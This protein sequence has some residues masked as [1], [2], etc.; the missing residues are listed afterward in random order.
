MAGIG[1]KHI[2]LEARVTID[3][4][5]LEQAARRVS[6]RMRS[7]VTIDG[8]QIEG[9]SRPLG[10]I[11]GQAD[12][13]TKSLAA[14]NARVIAFG[15]SVA[16]I[17]GVS[18][19]FKSLLVTTAKVEKTFADINIVLN[20]SQK[21][22]KRFGDGIFDVARNTAQS[23]DT[24]AQGALEFARQG[25]SMEESLKRINDA[26]ILT[27]LTG[28]DVTE[29]VEGLTA[30][31]NTFKKE[32]I[33]TGEVINKLAE[34]DIAFAVSSEDLIKGLERAGG[35]AGQARVSFEELASMIAVVQER[36]ARGGSVIGNALRTIFAR[37]QGSEA[38]NA[39]EAIGVAVRD[40]E[41][42]FRSTTAVLEDLSR[43]FKNL[44]DVTQADI[45]Q[46]V[47]GKRQRETLIALFGEMEGGTGRWAKALQTVGS[48]AETAYKKNEQLNDT[49]DAMVKQTGVSIQQLA[50]RIGEIG[51]QDNLK[52]LLEGFNW[53]IDKVNALFSPEEGSSL[54]KGFV[55][56]LGSAITSSP[57]VGLLL[58]IFAK[59]S[60]DVAKFGIQGLKSLLGINRA[61]QQQANLQE[62]ILHTLMREPALLEELN[63]KGMTRVHQE[64]LL[65]KVLKDQ[66][67]EYAKLAMIAKS[68]SPAVYRA[69]ARST[70]GGISLPTSAGGFIPNAVQ[71][72]R[73]NI[74]RGVGGARGGDKP[75]LMS[76]FNFGG[77]RRGPMVAHTGEYIVD[78]YRG[79]GGSAIFNRDMVGSM[80]M[81]RGARPIAAGGYIP[82]FAP[83]TFKQLLDKAKAKRVGARINAAYSAVSSPAEAE[84]FKSAFGVADYN[85]RARASS[86]GETFTS[87]EKK[88]KRLR[89]E[90]A[91]QKKRIY[92]PNIAMIVPQVLGLRRHVTGSKKAKDGKTY[93]VAFDKVGFDPNVDA[94]VRNDKEIDA[95]T[96]KFALN[97]ANLEAAKMSKGGQPQ[98]QKLDK[99]ANT[100][101]ISSLSG[102]IFETAVSSLVKATKE[103]AK[104]PETA[105]WDFFGAQANAN[106]KALFP[107]LGN[108]Q[109]IE[110][111][112]RES[113]DTKSSMFSKVLRDKGIA[114]A[115]KGYIPNF[116]GGPLEE[117]IGREKAAGLPINQIRINQDSR[118]RKASNP[119]GLAVTNT[120]DEPTG[121]IPNFAKKFKDMTDDELSAIF[122]TRGG[123][124]KQGAQKHLE[125]RGID[126][127]ELTKTSK[128][129]GDL[130]TKLFGASFALSILEGSTQEASGVFGDI[131]S[132]GS[133]FVSSLVNAALLIDLVKTPL[134]KLSK[135]EVPAG[136]F[137][138]GGL[139]GLGKGVGGLGKVAGKVLA[140]A[141]LGPPGIALAIGSALIAATSGAL[142]TYNK[143][144]QEQI[145]DVGRKTAE[146]RSKISEEINKLISDNPDVLK[147]Q[148]KDIKDPS[149]LTGSKLREIAKKTGLNLSSDADEANAQL[150]ELKNN[151]MGI[152]QE[153]ESVAEAFTK[154]TTKKLLDSQ[155]TAQRELNKLIQ[156]RIS[157]REFLL[158]LQAK[159]LNSDNLEKK[160]AETQLKLIDL[161][162]K[163]V[164][165]VSGGIISALDTGEI[166]QTD[167][168]SADKAKEYKDVIS[169]IIGDVKNL[170]ITE[171][172]LK[173]TLNEQLKSLIKNDTARESLIDLAVQELTNAKA[174][175]KEQELQLTVSE[176]RELVA[177]AIAKKEEI[178]LERLKAQFSLTKAIQDSQRELEKFRNIEQKELEIKVKQ[179]QLD[180]VNLTEKDKRRIEEEISNLELQ[181]N[182]FS[183]GE[184]L[185]D[186]LRGVFEGVFDQ[187]VA[188]ELLR[189]EDER[190]ANTII[191]AFANGSTTM[192]K[193]LREGLLDSSEKAGYKFVDVLKNNLPPSLFTDSGE[194]ASGERPL[195]GKP[196]LSLQN[197]TPFTP[198]V[199]Q[200]SSVAA[201]PDRDRLEELRNEIGN[202]K[203]KISELKEQLRRLPDEQRYG[204]I[205]TGRRKKAGDTALSKSELINQEI[206]AHKQKLKELDAEWERMWDAAKSQARNPITDTTANSLFNFDPSQERANALAFN[207]FTI[208]SL[209][210]GQNATAN[211]TANTATP[212]GALTQAEAIL[213]VEEKRLKI[214][215]MLSGEQALQG[216]TAEQ[217]ANQF[218]EVYGI[219]GDAAKALRPILEN[220]LSRELERA[221]AA[222]GV[223]AQLEKQNAELIRRNGL[224]PVQRGFE[225]AK[226][227]LLQETDE[228]FYERIA[229]DT[230][231]DFANNMATALS[232]AA[233]GAKSLKDAL[234]DAAQ[235]F[236]SALQQAFMQR[237]VNTL[238]GMVIP[239]KAEGGLVTGGSGVR[240]DVPHMLMGG[241]YVIKK[242][243]VKKYGVGYLE[244]L[245]NQ[246]TPRMAGGGEFMPIGHYGQGAITGIED[247]ER[248]AN[249]RITSGARDEM[250][251]GESS[252]RIGLEPQ[253]SRLTAFGMRRGSPLQEQLWEQQQQAR[254]LIDQKKEYDRQ[255]EEQ[256]KQALKQL[257]VGTLLS[258]GLAYG[259]GKLSNYVQTGKVAD[260]LNMSRSQFKNSFSSSEA[261]TNFMNKLGTLTPN[262]REFFFENYGG[263]NFTPRNWGY[264]KGGMT[265][266][267]PTAM[268]MGGEYVIGKQAVSQYGRNFFESINNMSA[269][270]PRYAV[271]GSTAPPAG[272]S[273]SKE[274]DTNIS[275][276]VNSDGSSQTQAG[277]DNSQ[278]DMKM[279]E[280]IRKEVVKI[281]EEE[282]RVSG[283]F[284]SRRRGM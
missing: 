120:R 252:A 254:D 26:L 142:V 126:V 35:S 242:D 82:N 4:R 88:A 225:D 129:L 210:G 221:E 209:F 76:N 253:S 230:P 186:G 224:T 52:D 33:T 206:E 237:A 248:F 155:V 34:L 141:A 229:R 185:K 208:D 147:E 114:V 135:I 150:I 45:I 267:S 180:D 50:S 134:T 280:R 223:T 274:G 233:T 277:T 83:Q 48:E 25:L 283:A 91:L 200:A 8:R 111:K 257:I 204:S 112:I 171:E 103:Q 247:L 127:N 96:K 77:G 6:N 234:M 90:R 192:E 240:D 236:L 188:P 193:I 75:V 97:L 205:R 207:P 222:K 243:A 190:R 245:N 28:L 102:A 137:K 220:L 133:N 218:L 271:G 51:L 177:E 109:K 161:R 235:S 148:L 5:S 37:L 71:E 284:S 2:G 168:V 44:D 174:L 81:P 173:E 166:F 60:Y 61:A 42:N 89:E 213:T 64:Q 23:F 231:I 197:F 153:A 239:G 196:E 15:A 70:K 270:A 7:S 273:S 232:Q 219:Q 19:A 278:G 93:Q 80:G 59:L 138:A 86:L 16:I 157:E 108:S 132:T 250:M 199:N 47:A 3:N 68:I 92:D 268:L 251:F 101:A 105:R 12:E 182:K 262:D 246:V 255:Q 63:K 69:G 261:Q 53:L 228:E 57:V 202:E 84:Q 131:A 95:A 149:K 46:K 124:Q 279:A 241:E 167:I 212:E 175:L 22:L 62:A 31:V 87:R 79:S 169:G 17:N 43:E 39:V 65:L 143:R 170:D 201:I 11:T 264:S 144:K 20:A 198:R 100:G 98:V 244:A 145:R 24:V 73:E 156:S 263:S 125:Q 176:K 1:T 107:D 123:I 29:S 216:Q 78:N 191:Q 265:K 117:A 189:K 10:K 122:R 121:R 38:I 94:R 203:D 226:K 184:N 266:K 13:F 164:Q 158:S 130:S 260:G 151:L 116:S 272:A 106:L 32:G 214:E 275:I 67:M 269:P 21:D 18:D 179:L 181:I 14:S 41:G 56:G 215:Q 163:A 74:R 139:K 140:G 159:S 282:K 54:A 256:K 99:L 183:V 154:T 55:K 85:M 128:G 115:A 238:V 276:V 258:A 136:G 172:K 162:R 9:I 227:Q 281:I 165:D 217:L 178:V 119:M 40:A 66:Q 195:A 194:G 259:A 187:F 118:L 104:R 146:A 49:L 36:T 152:R 30:A 110:A 72:E 160:A 211:A 113:P 249:Q 58:A 27:R